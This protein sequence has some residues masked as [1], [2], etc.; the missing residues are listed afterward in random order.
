MTVDD[1][2]K[3]LRQIIDSLINDVDEKVKIALDL[4]A[5]IKYRIQTSGV[6]ANGS[7]FDGYS[8]PYK[9]VRESYGVQTGHFDF[10]VTGEAW[11]SLQPEIT[12]DKGDG[13]LTV[14]LTPTSE[15]SRKKF[16]GNLKYRPNFMDASKDEIDLI[17][18]ANK[19]RILDKFDEYL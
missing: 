3:R 11:G 7:P 2:N 10:T 5:L 4:K 6:D 14:V 1:F 13:D 16:S 18:E 17:A 19:K 8:T 12:L 9:K 15:L